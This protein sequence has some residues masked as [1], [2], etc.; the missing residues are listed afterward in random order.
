METLKEGA[1]GADVIALPNSLKER[2]F[3]PGV[4]DGYVQLTGRAYYAKFGPL[5]GVPDL[6]SNPDKGCDLVIA[7]NRLAAFISSKQTPIKA[8]LLENNFATARKFVNGGSNGLGRFTSTYQTRAGL[9][10]QL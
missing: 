3:P 9:F 8:A 4:I 10:P 2:G 5:I 6:I 1:S 7:A